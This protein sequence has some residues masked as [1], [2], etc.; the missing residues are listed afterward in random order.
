MPIPALGLFLCGPPPLRTQEHRA[1]L[2]GR[3]GDPQGEAIPAAMVSVIHHANGAISATV[4]LP[5]GVN[6]FLS[7]E[8]H[9]IPAELAGFKRHVRENLQLSTGAPLGT[10]G[11]VNDRNIWLGA[12]QVW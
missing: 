2:T 6:P 1:T 9:T 12:R 5:D 10:P 4:S 3:V 8:Q 11:V 7:P